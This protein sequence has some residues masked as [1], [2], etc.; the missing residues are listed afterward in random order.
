MQ[1]PWLPNDRKELET[2]AKTS[3]FKNY[4]KFFSRSVELAKARE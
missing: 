1:N 4:S 2:L 3:D